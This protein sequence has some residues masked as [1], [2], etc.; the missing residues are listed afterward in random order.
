MKHDEYW[1]ASSPSNLPS[2]IIPKPYI[3]ETHD[4]QPKL[5]P[6]VQIRK[7]ENV[8]V[9]GLTNALRLQIWPA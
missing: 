8:N 3:D 5:L 4:L 1:D 2:Q 9:F 6:I 7:H